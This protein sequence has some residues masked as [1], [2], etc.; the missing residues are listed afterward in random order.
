MGGSMDR[1]M[2]GWVDKWMAG[3]RE[4]TETRREQTNSYR[5][6]LPWTCGTDQLAN[7][8]KRLGLKPN[9]H[10]DVTFTLEP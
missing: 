1:W 4:I 5:C 7:D 8:K 10:I 6:P 3:W 2:C 9:S